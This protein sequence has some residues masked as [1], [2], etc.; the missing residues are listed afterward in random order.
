MT[1]T[2]EKKSKKS[3][4]AVSQDID[5]K[6]ASDPE[7]LPRESIP[8]ENY[9]MVVLGC[10]PAG[11][12]A[13]I[14]SSKLGKKVALVEPKFIGGHCTHYG[15]LPSK[16]FREAATHLT[17]YNLRFYDGASLKEEPTMDALVRR[18]NWVRQ[19]EIKTI[20]EHLRK[21]KID[22][23]GGFGKFKDKNSINIY[24]EKGDV[25]KILHFDNCVI[26]CGSSPYLDPNIP[27]NDENIF[28]SDNIL[29]MK[30]L[31]RSIIIV[32]GGIIGCEYA[33]IFSILGVRVNLIERR[34]EIL[35]LI[36]RDMRADL[37]NQLNKRKARLFL[38]D[39]MT[40]IQSTE[41]GKVEVRL[42][43]EKLI[44]AEAALICIF[45]V[46]NTHSLNLDKIGVKMN[47]RG[48]IDVSESLE[49]SVKNIYAAGDVIGAPALASTSFEQGRIAAQCAFMK[50]C[51][52]MSSNLPIGIYTIPEIS[53]IGP[54]EDEL[55]Q[56]KIPYQVG[57][58]YFKDTSRG[59]IMGAL[60]GMLKIIFHQQN[61]KVL[62]VHVIG[63]NA[64]ELVH[65]GQA[66]IE[67]GGTIDYFL[68]KVFNFPT[69]A[70]TYKYAAHNGLNRLVDV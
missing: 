59:A 54:T 39:E 22:L 60:D 70:E 20:Q 62:A 65:V 68:D 24:N 8:E 35:S 12:K 43:S 42:A 27:Y 32:G 16:T 1:T 5:L 36:D 25:V 41:N 51:K 50:T 38:G 7:S 3:E 19:N 69:L 49:T 23:I 37:V 66:V 14:A 10:G 63:E 29:K 4:K 57:K 67:L 61:R 2:A 17:N 56:N 48:V 9:D 30:K 53:Y 31:P 33:S 55:T 40:S 58:A 15:T 6:Q 26:S 18:V 52:P 21:N 44:R 64:T 47:S 46:V 28:C 34:S 11:Q 45:R 13:A